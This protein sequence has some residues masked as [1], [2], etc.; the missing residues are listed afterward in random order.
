MKVVCTIGSQGLSDG[1]RFV[2]G[3]VYEVDDETASALILNGYA[4]ECVIEEFVADDNIGPEKVVEDVVD[5]VV[6]DPP[7]PEKVVDDV[8]DDYAAPKTSD[9]PKKTKNKRR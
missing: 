7:E 1:R 3:D 6:D 5:V 2:R 4:E 8:V 9:K